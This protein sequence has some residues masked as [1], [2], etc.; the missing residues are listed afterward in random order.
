VE[1]LMRQHGIA[2]RG[3]RKYKATTDSQ[4]AW[5][6][7]QNHL[8]RNFTPNGPNQRW[9]GDITSVWT[10]EGWLYLAVVLDLFSRK[11]IGWSLG[12][13]MTRQLAIDALTMAWFARGGNSGGGKS[14]GGKSGGGKSGKETVRAD[15]LM[16]HSDRGSQYASADFQRRLTEYE[17]MGSMRRKGNCWDNAVVESLFGSL[18]V[19]R[20][21]GELYATREEAKAELLDWIRFYNY[22]RRHSTLLQVSPMQFEAKWREAQRMAA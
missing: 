6:V 19:E 9:A 11:V 14:G 8:D 18:K 12:E 5:P 7:A 4:H 3:K 22:E 2:A 21:H 15:G 17:I 1:R 13:R 20:L 10:A 16:F